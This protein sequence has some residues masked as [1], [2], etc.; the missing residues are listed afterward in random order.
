MCLVTKEGCHTAATSIFAGTGVNF[1]SDGRPY[2]G[3]AV[4]SIEYV[5]GY[6]RA[7]VNSWVTLL[8]NLSL[9]AKIQP[10]AAYSAL[11]HGLLSKWTYLCHTIPNIG[12]LLKPLD[13]IL[14]NELI[15]A[16]TGRPPLGVCSLCSASKNGWAGDTDSFQ[17]SRPR[18]SIILTCNLGPPR[19]YLRAK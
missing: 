9:I 13:H 8:R 14:Q 11:T 19:P 2:L 10:H 1:T 7:K 12:D 4:G 16:L 15:P 3:A 6:V 5:E 17:A 18:V